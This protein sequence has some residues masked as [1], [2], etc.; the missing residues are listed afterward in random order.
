M[1]F[2]N[3]MKYIP[4]HFIAGIVKTMSISAKKQKGS[5]STSLFLISISSS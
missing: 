4:Y 3:S 2:R 5:Y 1:L